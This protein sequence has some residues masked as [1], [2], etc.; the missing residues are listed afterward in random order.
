VEEESRSFPPPP[1]SPT[2][3]HRNISPQSTPSVHVTPPPSA[4]GS[5]SSPWPQPEEY[6]PTFASPSRRRSFVPQGGPLEHPEQDDVGS[7]L[8]VVPFESISLTDDNT[9]QELETTR[10]SSPLQRGRSLPPSSVGGISVDGKTKNSSF[11][12]GLHGAEPESMHDAP[13]S[14]SGPLSFLRRSTSSRAS[15]ASKS[16]N[17]GHRSESQ[18]ENESVIH[19]PT[20]KSGSPTPQAEGSGMNGNSPAHGRIEAPPAIPH[21][22]NPTIAALISKG[23]DPNTAPS[24][25][26]T[27]PVNSSALQASQVEKRKSLPLFSALKH[28]SSRKG[29]EKDTTSA[30][31]ADSTANGN[32]AHTDPSANGLHHS[33]AG[34][35]MLDKVRSQTRPAYLPPKDKE[36]DEAHLRAW[37]AMMAEARAAE[38]KRQERQ[39]AMRE[40]REK[41]MAE[42]LP[43]WESI[44]AMYGDGQRTDW[45]ETLSA[46]P[47]LRRV[48]FN[49]CPSH[50]RGRVWAM[51][52][53][54]GLALSKGG[55][56]SRSVSFKS[57]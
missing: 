18:S 6:L 23:L 27:S 35:S 53:G 56:G 21:T 39:R 43:I 3:V 4:S 57:C 50:L 19:P 47:K 32:Q 52:I 54:N 40:E 24:Y 22:A 2:F 28:G 25:L 51:C 48:W 36:E 55:F 14:S 34:P 5:H 10:R 29:K 12:V 30:H 46:D 13:K 11:S 20:G 49:G 45:K 8:P 37:E 41:R 15:I 33:T 9:H 7:Q 44:L 31:A 26:A 1:P 42:S 17:S 38:A 16:R